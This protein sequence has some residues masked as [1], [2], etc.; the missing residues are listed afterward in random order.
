MPLLFDRQ[1][2]LVLGNLESDDCAKDNYHSPGAEFTPT[3]CMLQMRASNQDVTLESHAYR[4]LHHTEQ[5]GS[6]TKVHLFFYQ[7]AYTF[8]PAAHPSVFLSCCK[9][10]ERVSV[11]IPLV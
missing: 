1:Q 2:G 9:S 6:V 11:T 4:A 10:L 5:I 7:E 3:G 8:N